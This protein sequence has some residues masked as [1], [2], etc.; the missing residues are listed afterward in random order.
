MRQT[1][2]DSWLAYPTEKTFEVSGFLGTE[3]T[4]ILL[5]MSLSRWEVG[6]R[7]ERRFDSDRPTSW[8]GRED[9]GDGVACEEI[10][11]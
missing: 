5:L 4:W 11:E 1:T 7:E 9:E 6:K 8:R 3:C 10:L 2:S